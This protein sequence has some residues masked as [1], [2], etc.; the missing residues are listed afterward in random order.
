M[1][2]IT[3]V[4][5]PLA[6]EHTKYPSIE[7]KMKNLIKDREEALA[8][9]ELAKNCMARRRK[10]TFIPFEKGQKIWLDSRHFIIRRLDQN[11]KDLLKLRKYLDPLPIS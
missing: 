1:L 9:H 2:G 8:A 3:P 7:E 11:V 6:F 4:A 5:I 10:D